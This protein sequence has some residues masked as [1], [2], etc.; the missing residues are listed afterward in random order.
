MA[1]VSLMYYDS[2]HNEVF[3]NGFCNTAESLFEFSFGVNPDTLDQ[4]VLAEINKTRTLYYTRL[5]NTPGVQYQSSLE[6]LKSEL[7][8]MGEL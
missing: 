6:L 7:T 8:E 1:N 4:E 3:C 2:K 5:K